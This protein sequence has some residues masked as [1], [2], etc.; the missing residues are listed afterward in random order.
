MTL[1]P[2]AQRLPL[3]VLLVVSALCSA[4]GPGLYRA[5]SKVVVLT[6]KN[7]DKVSRLADGPVM[8]PL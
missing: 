7:Y 2:M 4:S 5:G 8:S 3:V 6:D 1:A